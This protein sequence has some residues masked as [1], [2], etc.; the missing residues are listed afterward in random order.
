MIH[1]PNLILST[2]TILGIGQSDHAM[3]VHTV[4]PVSISAHLARILDAAAAYEVKAVLSI[5]A[6]AVMEPL[7]VAQRRHGTLTYPVI[8]NIPSYVRDAGDYGLVGAGVRRLLRLGFGNLARLGYYNYSRIFKVLQKDFNT[9]IQIFLDVEMAEFRRLQPP[10]VFLDGQITDLSVAFDNRELLMRF[11]EVMRDRYHTEPGL[12]TNNLGF[13]VSKLQAWD[14]PI[15]YLITPCNRP[16]FAMNPN[17]VTCESVF[18]QGQFTF[19]ADRISPGTKPDAT[20]Y[21]YLHAQNIRCAI[22]D[23]TESIDF[24]RAHR[25]FGPVRTTLS[26]AGV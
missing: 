3:Q 6:A 24:E 18:R 7:K 13:L 25:L 11:A 23:L 22:L 5:E 19:V 9:A 17:Q 10:A 12:V 4:P 15:Q 20:T 2:R 26:P 16:G 14:V 21:D 8:P 1:F